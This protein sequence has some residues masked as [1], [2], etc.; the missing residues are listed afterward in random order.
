MRKL[1]LQVSITLDGYI[2]GPNGDMDWATMAWSDDLN[3]YVADL[4]APV[5]T[6]VLGRKLAEGFIPY[7]AG[8][9]DDNT[10]PE[11]EGGRMFTNTPKIVFSNTLP[12]TAA[13]EKGW[14]QTTISSSNLAEEIKRLKEKQGND[15][16][17]CGGATFV[18]ALIE[19][20]LVDDY[21]LL[22]NPV[23]IGAG[24]AIFKNR[25]TPLHL[26]LVK[27][28]SFEC[29]IVGVHYRAKQD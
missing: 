26:N 4:L 21:Y 14:P 5:D 1:K 15:I 29:G 10:N 7:W 8:V 23:A 3:K 9:A 11:Q 24:L 16:Y 25:T 28:T 17:A 2:G 13:A 20:N 19:H 22:V 27:A 6:L 18:S 12:P